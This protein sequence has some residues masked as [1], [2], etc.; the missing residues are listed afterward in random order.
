[1][2][3]SLPGFSVHGIFQARILEWVAISFSRRSSRP[4]DWTWVYH[5]VGRCFTVWATREVQLISNPF[6]NRLKLWALL[7]SPIAPHNFSIT[8]YLVISYVCQYTASTIRTCALLWSYSILITYYI[9]FVKFLYSQS[10]NGIIPIV[11]VR[12]IKS[13]II[14]YYS[15]EI[16]HEKPSVCY[17][18]QVLCKIK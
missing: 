1:M 13:F 5:I 16:L 10:H 12:A 4:R 17:G 18:K 15:W 7:Y 8:E 2:D 11:G 14:Y 6:L 9:V 3:C